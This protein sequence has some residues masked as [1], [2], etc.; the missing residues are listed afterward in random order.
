MKP[1][2]RTVAGEND[3]LQLHDKCLSD[4][5]FLASEPIE[6]RVMSEGYARRP[7]SFRNNVTVERLSIA[8][9]SNL[10]YDGVQHE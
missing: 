3:S 4:E 7:D 6:I 8:E 10:F 2:L 1:R 9:I 5:P